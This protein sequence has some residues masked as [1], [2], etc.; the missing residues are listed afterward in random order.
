MNDLNLENTNS[1]LEETYTQEE[2]KYLNQFQNDTQ[3]IDNFGSEDSSNNSQ[4]NIEDNTNKDIKNPSKE[5]EKLD[6]LKTQLNELHEIIG[7]HLKNSSY[8]NE[9]E[10]NPK[11]VPDLEKDPINFMKFLAD[12]Q[13]KIF[14]YEIKKQK[15]EEIHKKNEAIENYLKDSIKNLQKETPDFFDASSHLY[16]QRY[17]QLKALGK[18]YNNFQTDEEIQKQIG[19]E[20]RHIIDESIQQKEDPAK[21]L[22]DIAIHMGYSQKDKNLEQQTTNALKEFQLKT[23]SAKT[24]TSK[25]GN[26]SPDPYSLEAISAM[27]EDEFSSW[28]SK[29]ENDFHFKKLMGSI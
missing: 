26:N 8:Q 3:E 17:Q 1:N 27:T 25:G 13:K 16:Q 14:D 28:I 2:Q 24:L 22:Y 5:Q 11:D 19:L 7:N 20:L 6:E 18:I 29:E 21:I 23:N 9:E 4:Q 12:Q 10:I 15:G